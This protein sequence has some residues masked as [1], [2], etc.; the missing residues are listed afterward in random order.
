MAFIN[1]TFRWWIHKSYCMMKIPRSR[2]P[3]LLED[4]YR[5]MNIKQW[6]T[7]MSI[8]AGVMYVRWALGRCVHTIQMLKLC[9]VYSPKATSRPSA[10]NGTRTKAWIN[11]SVWSTKSYSL[12]QSVCP[13]A[14]VDAIRAS[15]PYHSLTSD[16]CLVLWAYVCSP[17]RHSLIT[18]QFPRSPALYRNFSSAYFFFATLSLPVF[19]FFHPLQCTVISHV[20]TRLSDTSDCAGVRSD[21]TCRRRLYAHSDTQRCTERQRVPLDLIKED[22]LSSDLG[23]N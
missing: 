15:R 8:I 9:S 12:W 6:K 21:Q 3:K 13:H 16:S 1:C 14:C 5:P 2:P 11:S 20:F 7:N 22:M 19:P 4:F 23:G 17:F 18:P 10:S